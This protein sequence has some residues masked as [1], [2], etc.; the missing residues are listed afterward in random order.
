MVDDDDDG[1]AI[2]QGHHETT[3]QLQAQGDQI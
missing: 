1:F 2:T 3:P